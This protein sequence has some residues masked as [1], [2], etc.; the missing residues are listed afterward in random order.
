MIYNLADR[1]LEILG[2]NYFIADSASVI[3]SVVMHQN[4]SIWFGAVL[5]GDNDVIT[6][7]ENSNVQDLSV[8]HVDP[9]FPL[10]I[11]KNVTVG[12]KVM[13]HGCEIGDNSLV[14]INSVI[15]NGAKI[16]KNCLIGANSLISEN[17]VIPDGSLVMGSPGKVV[18]Q[19]SEDQMKGL[20]MSALHYV[21]NFKRYKRD[22]EETS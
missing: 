6:I 5:R 2:D 3:G 15:L 17:K 8:L 1:K 10:T 4:A 19:L 16:G 12:H 7:G 22:L 18:K 21:E 13:L 9:G 20:E 11:G 14:G